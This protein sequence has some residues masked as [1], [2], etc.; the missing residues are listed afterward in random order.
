MALDEIPGK[1]NL[2]ADDPF[3]KY[4]GHM[5]NAGIDYMQHA[6]KIEADITQ[7]KENLNGYMKHTKLQFML[8]EKS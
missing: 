3:I 8:D 2:T 4:L 7:Y 5:Y 6:K 1:I